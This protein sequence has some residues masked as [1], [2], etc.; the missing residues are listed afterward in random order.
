[1]SPSNRIVNIELDIFSSR[2][3]I[4]NIEIGGLALSLAYGAAGTDAPRTFAF[5]AASI[6]LLWMTYRLRPYNRVY[7]LWREVR[8][9]LTQPRN[10][11][12]HFPLFNAGWFALSLVAA[13]IVTKNG[14]L[15]L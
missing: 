6:V 11:W 13:G 2:A 4:I 8:H 5:A 15:G 10:I 14:I 12:R 7:C 9:P 1:M 3:K